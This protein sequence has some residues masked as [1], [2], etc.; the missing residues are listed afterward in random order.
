MVSNGV[1]GNTHEAIVG[2]HGDLEVD[3]ETGEI[4]HFTYVATQIP[5]DVGLDLVS[6]T[7]DYDF[8]NVGG[9]AYILPSHSAIEMISPRLSIRNDIDF[10]EYRKFSADSTIDFAPGK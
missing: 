5:E 8:A 4:L 3:R 1:A 7:V 10:R 9:R 2:F 6:T